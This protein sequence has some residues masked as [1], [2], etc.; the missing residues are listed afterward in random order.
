M[1]ICGSVAGIYLICLLLFQL[2]FHL[3][4]RAFWLFGATVTTVIGLI[5]GLPEADVALLFYPLWCCH[6]Y[7]FLEIRTQNFA[8]VFRFTPDFGISLFNMT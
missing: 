3:F 1:M 5:F 7:L 6:F 2:K 4:T 8:G